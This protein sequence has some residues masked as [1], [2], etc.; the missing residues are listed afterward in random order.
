[1]S[2]QNTY[3]H[4]SDESRFKTFDPSGTEWPD[5]VTDVQSA[6]SLISASARTDVGLPIADKTTKGI[7]KLSTDDD[8]FK[9]ENDTDAVTPK[10]MDYK[11]RHPH[12]SFD[13]YGTTKY[14]SNDLAIGFSDTETTIT[15]VTLGYVFDNR[16]ATESVYGT[17][18]VAT[19]LQANAGEDDSVVITAKKLRGA[20]AAMV[21]GY[22]DA[23]E[24]VTGIV[25]LA[26]VAQIREGVV[27]NGYAISPASFNALGG[28]EQYMGVYKV[29]TQVD[30]NSGTN[31]SVVV[32]A[33]K[34]V[35]T[36]GSSSRYGVVKLTTDLNNAEDG[37][38]LSPKAPIVSKS[39]TINGKK[40]D[41][42]SLT[43]SA[44]D[45]NAWTKQESDSRYM[46]NTTGICNFLYYS[47][48]SYYSGDGNDRFV[49]YFD[50]N[51]PN[52]G[53]K[54]SKMKI[55]IVMVDPGETSSDG[56]RSTYY[57][58]L[59][60]MVGG[61]DYGKTT[62]PVFIYHSLSGYLKSNDSRRDQQ[63]G[64]FS[65]SKTI[66]GNFGGDFVRLVIGGR[67]VRPVTGGYVF[68]ANQPMYVNITLF[69]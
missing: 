28:T 18:R 67:N 33:K 69:N 66:S 6:L 21:P 9:G 48:N 17:M 19:Q 31:D 51:L 20:V 46:R 11:M 43:I 58:P 10:Q 12:A 2:T 16:H 44:G 13:V 7:V 62:D 29:A 42:N 5:N 22:D 49:S 32:T 59:N 15:P 25:R 50:I 24:S 53:K 52:D 34:F 54:Y 26:T 3:K 55:D 23:T 61:V 1:M 27:K 68:V 63:V 37:Y 45:V 65:M 64:H 40:M 38:A 4:I 30:M 35:S 14:A 57:N 60:I 36:K 41:G 39:F 8:A 47:G 56:W